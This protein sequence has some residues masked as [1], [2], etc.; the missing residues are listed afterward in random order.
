[1]TPIFLLMGLGPTEMIVIAIVG[2]LLFGR[3]LPDVGRSVG[4]SFFEFKRGLG[5]LQGEMNEMQQLSREVRSTE[6]TPKPSAS[7]EPEEPPG[8]EKV[9]EH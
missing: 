8:E 4:K 6:P 5:G 7:D 3:R 1:M 2:L 9:D